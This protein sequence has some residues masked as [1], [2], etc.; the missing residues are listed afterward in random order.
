MLLNTSGSLGHLIGE[1][2]QSDKT[3]QA[4]ILSLVD[5]THTPATEFLDDAIVGDGLANE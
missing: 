4:G 3:I 1:E 2:F 5:H